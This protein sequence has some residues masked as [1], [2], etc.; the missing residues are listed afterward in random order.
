M[1]AAPATA[2]PSSGILP[3]SRLTV[4]AG[5]TMGVTATA[6]HGTAAYLGGQFGSIGYR[7]PGIAAFSSSTGRP[8]PTVPELEAVAANAV[9]SAERV[10][11]DGDGGVYALGLANGNTGSGAVAVEGV[12]VGARWLHLG[13]DGRPDR[14]LTPR[15]ARPSGEVSVRDVV[16]GRDGTR[17]VAGDF[18]AVD[19]QPRAGLAAIDA[20]GRLTD[21]APAVTGGGVGRL[22]IVGDGI[23]LV[24]T[25]LQ[26]FTA[27]AGQ[28]RAGL[29]LV[30]AATGAPRPWAPSGLT[31]EDADRGVAVDGQTV[32]LASARR[33]QV[34]TTT[35]A[36]TPRDLR[37]R[38]DDEAGEIRAIAVHGGK[39]YV[40]GD[41]RQLGAQDDRPARS[42][43]AEVDPATGNATDWAP[44]VTAASGA[45]ALAVTDGRLYVAYDQLRQSAEAG[46]PCGLVAL[47]RATGRRDD[48]FSTGINGTRLECGSGTTSV[49]SAGARVWAAG[50]FS[51]VAV[52]R[53]DGLAAIDVAKDELLPWAPTLRD[54][55]IEPNVRDLLVSRDGATVYLAIEDYDS[56]QING[57]DRRSVAAVAATG[58]ANRAQDVRPWDPAPQGVVQALDASP[59]GERI[60]LGGSFWALGETSRANLA[61]VAAGG[62][63]A[64]TTWAPE[65]DGGV[66]DLQVAGDGTVYA[67][68]G[69][70]QLGGQARNGLGAITADGTVT[71][72]DPQLDPA[73]VDDG[74]Q[75]L[76]LGP[77]SVY[78]AGGFTGT[79]GGA[80]RRNLAE[81][82]RS[83]ASATA[84]D[85]QARGTARTV[86]RL[87]DGSVYVIGP[88]RI[89]DADRP[90][91]A[92]A[93]APDGTLT[94]WKPTG[95][96]SN[97]FQGSAE[98]RDVAGQVVVPFRT[99]PA[100]DG[101]PQ[102][103]F[104]LYG[105]ATAP[106]AA[107]PAVPPVVAGLPV[108]DSRLTCA[109]GAYDGSRPL[110]RSY[111]WLRDGQPITGQT[112]VTY[113]TRA[114][115]VGRALSCRERVEN[116]A[117]ALQTES[118]RVRI[119]AG[120]PVSDAPPSV[121]GT[122]QPGST[123]TCDRG[124][125]S[126]DPDA[127]TYAW[128][129]DGT[130]LDGQTGATFAVTDGDVA[131]AL[132]CTVVGANAVGVSKPAR[133]AAVTVTRPST[134]GGGGGGNEQPSGGGGQQEQP[135][136]GPSG[137]PP[138]GP[139]PGG[140]QPQ[141]RPPVTPRPTVTVGRAAA[142]K[143]RAFTLRLT[144]SGSGR[145]TVVATVQAGRKTVTVATG[146]GAV[147]A[148]KAATV[149]MKATKAGTR[150]LRRGR[151]AKVTFR[152]TFTAA[153]GT[154]GATTKSVRVKVR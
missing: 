78:V 44:S 114:A 45:M 147:R 40:A 47:D 131:H 10:V 33:V 87:A 116:P 143:G 15:F 146:R 90:G 135:R 8:D 5:S 153:D 154:T 28:A 24:G 37:L 4:M 85:P 64:P 13:A 126:N 95:N 49:A 94:A 56:L 144:P 48:T 25:F 137:P 51:K 136:G 150:A 89:G 149:A 118:A 84:W 83:D 65:P 124:L 134:G 74:V 57:V 98:V 117:G 67:G 72:W 66:L 63:G 58:A 31:Q 108:A 39:L 38:R 121:T 70:T 14:T 152:V 41:F 111:A 122:A 105:P 34:V 82:R 36:G 127:F 11:P 16:V 102:T 148:G 107:S 35:G 119:V 139:T 110:Q 32:L 77:D 50:T 42:F 112:A 55:L 6:V 80:S 69:F 59:D 101:V 81:L 132:A 97:A 123:L 128:L 93:F 27:V 92:A 68:G 79:I 46:R 99:S 88:D 145:V 61:A 104:A 75:D 106:K 12:P 120:T 54:D 86:S 3:G 76:A 115:D 23:V 113:T 60:Y 7:A 52:E 20:D 17:Y 19:G 142:A 109:G 22:A 30:D 130:A 18:T 2:T 129:R 9:A 125:W 91:G 71:A 73:A 140:P 141:P 96:A 29:A 100:I 62:A 43:V 1:A 151:T 26:P 133:S 138:P 53:R 103:G 21:W